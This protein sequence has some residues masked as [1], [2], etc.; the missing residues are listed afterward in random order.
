[1][2][3]LNGLTRRCAS[4]AL[5]AGLKGDGAIYLG[6]YFSAIVLCEIAFLYCFVITFNLIDYTTCNTIIFFYLSS[7]CLSLG[8]NIFFQTMTIH[9]SFHDN[10]VCLP[11]TIIQ[12]IILRRITSIRIDATFSN[13]IIQF[14]D[15]PL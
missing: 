13:N 3:C 6:F 5:C 10:L 8:C 12:P 7:S 9:I 4:A 11:T 15:P 2:R 1:M 14:I